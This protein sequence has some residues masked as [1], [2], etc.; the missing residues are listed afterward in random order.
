MSNLLPFLRRVLH[1]TPPS[2]RERDEAAKG[3]GAAFLTE[4]TLKNYYGVEIDLN[5]L[6]AMSPGIEQERIETA[7]RLRRAA[8]RA[9][10][11]ELG[12]IRAERAAARAKT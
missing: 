1:R 9:I 11:H 2:A 7:E 12:T 6:L 8:W 4:A 3:A 5:T 10:D